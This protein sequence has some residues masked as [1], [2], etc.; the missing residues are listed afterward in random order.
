MRGTGDH[1]GCHPEPEHAKDARGPNRRS[2]PTTRADRD[3][4]PRD[5][6]RRVGRDRSLVGRERLRRNRRRLRG[7]LVGRGRE[8][9]PRDGDHRREARDRRPPGNV[10]GAATA[11]LCLSPDRLPTRRRSGAP[12]RTG[13][14]RR[15]RVKNV[16]V[17]R[18]DDRRCRLHGARRTRSHRVAQRRQRALVVDDR[19]ALGTRQ[20]QA[21]EHRYEKNRTDRE[22]DDHLF[23]SPVQ[24]PQGTATP[25]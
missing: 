21:H 20:P 5:R 22:D 2:V 1:D 16:N 25:N 17:I 11:P 15:W 19:S 12:V 14:A 10:G 9:L 8:P 3:R 24:R 4:L 23:P 7:R 18:D 13:P 6:S